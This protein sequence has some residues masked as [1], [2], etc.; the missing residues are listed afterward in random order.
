MLTFVSKVF[1]YNKIF[2]IAWKCLQPSSF[3]PFAY[4][5]FV[6]R[7]FLN[8]QKSFFKIAAVVLLWGF[9]KPTFYLFEVF[10]ILARFSRASAVGGRALGRV[11][12]NQI[13][14]PQFFKKRGPILCNMSVRK[15]KFS[16][17]SGEFPK[18]FLEKALLRASLPPWTDGPVFPTKSFSTK[19][20]HDVPGF[21]KMYF[22][23]SR[24]NHVLQVS[25]SQICHLKS[26][27]VSFN[28]IL[29]V[30]KCVVLLL[31]SCRFKSLW[32]TSFLIPWQSY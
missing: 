10:S 1:S 3:W 22:F 32:I 25:R 31:G 30:L 23:C 6:S 2:A 5:Y 20:S 28:L 17:P 7:C 27:Q 26:P 21:F 4:Q 19:V 29:V 24:I 9:S 13:L 15:L 11:P 18:N 8:L 16:S 12:S 14:A